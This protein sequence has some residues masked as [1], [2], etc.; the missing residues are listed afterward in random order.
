MK[1]TY[2]SPETIIVQLN[3][4]DLLWQNYNFVNNVSGTGGKSQTV[5][6]KENVVYADDDEYGVSDWDE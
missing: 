6:A 2:L 4:S 1:E 3:I 5:H